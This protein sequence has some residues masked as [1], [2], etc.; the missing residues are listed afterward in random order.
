[1]MLIMTAKDAVRE[2][3]LREEILE[4][5]DRAPELRPVAIGLF[6][7]IAALV[8][9]LR[10]PNSGQAVGLGGR[11][12]AHGSG[13]RTVIDLSATGPGVA[14]TVARGLA[15]RNIAWVDS[16]VSGGMA[17]AKAGTLAVMVSCPKPT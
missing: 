11:G 2:A 6:A 3:V 5:V 7:L 1:M 9:D 12:L 8:L 10:R 13:L 17:G 15:A 4:P 14:T 16:P